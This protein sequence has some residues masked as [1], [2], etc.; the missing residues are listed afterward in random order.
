MNYSMA[1]YVR[2]SWVRAKLSTL[3]N[4]GRVWITYIKVIVNESLGD[5]V[6][7]REW[8]TAVVRPLLKKLGLE[9]I[10]PN[11]TPVSNL[12]FISKVIERSMLLQVSK[13]CEEYQLQLDYQ[14]A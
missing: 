7:C 5:G 6:F 10:F 4:F 14:S 11:Y 1:H 13:H 8:K 9:L 3:I 12:T 2:W